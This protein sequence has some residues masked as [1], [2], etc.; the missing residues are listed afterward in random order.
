MVPSRRRCACHRGTWW[1]AVVSWW[2]VTHASRRAASFPRGAVRSWGPVGD[3]KTVKSQ[4]ASWRCA[5]RRGTWWASVAVGNSSITHVSASCVVSTRSR[6][7]WAPVGGVKSQAVRL[8]SWHLVG[9]C[10]VVTVGNLSITHVSASCAVSHT[11]PS[12]LGP[13]RWCQDSQVAGGAPLV[14]ALGGPLSCRGGL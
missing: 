7:S 2:S 4:E 6:R 1:P 14:V 10:C 9:Q 3:V 8:S 11:V 12:V 13:R 5:S